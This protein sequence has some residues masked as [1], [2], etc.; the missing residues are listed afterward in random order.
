MFSIRVYKL[1]PGV[2]LRDG[3]HTLDHAFWFP[4]DPG[5]LESSVARLNATSP[6]SDWCQRRDG[7]GTGALP[8]INMLSHWEHGQVTH[9]LA[10]S[11]ADSQVGWDSLTYACAGH[12]SVIRPVKVENKRLVTGRK[13]ATEL[14]VTGYFIKHTTFLVFCIHEN[15]F[16]T[17]M[18]RNRLVQW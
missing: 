18:V 7:G 3:L 4:L 12:M 1:K 2:C 16:Y 6:G 5:S 10:R 17:Y 9:D 11:S 14:W 15:S 13:A 8:P